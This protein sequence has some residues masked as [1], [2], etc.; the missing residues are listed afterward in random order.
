MNSSLVTPCCWIP[1]DQFKHQHQPAQHVTHN[2]TVK[3]AAGLLSQILTVG[4]HCPVS[5]SQNQGTE[6]GRS[7]QQGMTL[8]SSPTLLVALHSC[9]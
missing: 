6:G 3:A 5:L 9:L 7:H 4:S 1:L 8:R 2:L